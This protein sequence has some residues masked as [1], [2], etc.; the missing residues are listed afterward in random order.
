MTPYLL[1][2]EISFASSLPR[3]DG[4]PLVFAQALPTRR[5]TR[6]GLTLR[7]WNDVGRPFREIALEA[8]R[9]ARRRAQTAPVVLLCQPEGDTRLRRELGRVDPCLPLV[10]MAE[11]SRFD[12]GGADD[13]TRY[14]QDHHASVVVVDNLRRLMPRVHWKS[15]RSRFD[16]T[17]REVLG[18]LRRVISGFDHEIEVVLF[19]HVARGKAEKLLAE[20]L[21]DEIEEVRL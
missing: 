1:D 8:L 13:L 5:R 6:R 7:Y 2:L 19:H 11:V 12:S 10:Y 14:V 4:R 3:W 20:G 18:G 9:L 15:P 16:A 17:E 21:V